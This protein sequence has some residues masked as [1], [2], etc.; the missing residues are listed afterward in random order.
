M[1]REPERRASSPA[2]PLRAV[3]NFVDGALA[4]LRGLGFVWSTRAA[5]LLSAVP[6]GV[7]ALL[8]ALA[9]GGSIHFVPEWMAQLWPGLSHSLGQFG[10]GVAKVLMTGIVAVLGLF[11]A[12]FITPALSAPALDHL[13]LLRERTLGAP[14]RRA[15]GFWRE[16]GCAIQA[17]ILAVLVFSP[18]LALLTLVTWVVPPAAVITFPLKLVVL[19][20]LLAWS[21]L[22]YP[23]S[24]RG[25]S[26]SMRMRLLAHNASRVLGF[27][28]ALALVFMVPLLPF[29]M[30]PASV[31][32]AAEIAVAM[33][34]E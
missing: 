19:A 31:A 24:L 13:V 10:S 11:A 4:L 22:D 29:L 26:V 34:R 30:L 18:L 6:I 2:Q 28:L 7:C 1:S 14:P 20:S 27:G 5:W 25:L 17:Q 3:V 16:L 8:S 32:A 12:Y 15:A 9:I 33:E 21:M 23:L